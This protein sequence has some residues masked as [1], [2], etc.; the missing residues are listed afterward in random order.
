MNNLKN[1]K[2]LQSI[3]KYLA[4]IAC[5]CLVFFAGFFTH[6]FSLDSELR[7]LN[8]FLKTYK[9]HYY[10]SDSNQSIVNVVSES[11]LDNYSDYFTKDEYEAYR[12]TS[13][14]K[15]FGFGFSVS[16][17]NNLYITKVLGNSP[18]ARAGVAV[19]GKI[20]G[21][22]LQ[23]ESE[24]TVATTTSELTNYLSTITTQEV[25]FK[26]DYNGSI[27]EFAILKSDYNESFVYY[28]DS[29]G[30]YHFIGDE[31]LTL[32]KKESADFVISDGWSYI[33]L[34]SFSG[35]KDG[36][37]GVVGQFAEVMN[38]FKNNNN[39]KLIIDLRSN[40]GGYMSVMCALC[41]YLCNTDSSGE[42]LCTTATY[43]DGK[44][45]NY[46]AKASKYSE[47]NFEK[48]I[49]LA[50][51]GSASASEALMGAVLDYDKQSNKNIVKVV[52]EPSIINN[53]VVYKSYGKGIMQTTFI[54]NLT[55]EAV[56]LTTAEICWP[57]SK[58]CIHGTGL[59]PAI[60]NRIVA[61]YTDNA[62]AFAQTL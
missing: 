28:T 45:E 34:T 11:L 1:N 41:Q 15:H 56:K 36:T 2:N 38:L 25:V 54:N 35:G 47:F 4:T 27:R 39:D 18:A 3:L 17:I 44:T 7:S 58:T 10:Y 46:N 55:G 50:N 37:L 14:G 20:V 61:N 51:S 60:D 52:L 59:T 24:Y 29:T 19:G 62:I 5:V 40:G 23:G 57:I 22:K 30:S 21:Y 48:I 26:I 32:T 33:C 9:E 42:F 6:Y 31:K 12:T 43:K 13:N 49:F 53:E 8:F 16:T